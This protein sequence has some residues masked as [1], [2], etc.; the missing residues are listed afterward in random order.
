MKDVWA[1]RAS[2]NVIDAHKDYLNDLTRISSREYKPTT[3]DILLARVRTTQVIMERYRIDGIEF[4]M[5][6]VG[7][8]RSERRK[9]IDCFDQVRRCHLRRRPQ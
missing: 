3:Q 2:I 7:G 5:Y 9:W 4:E 8:Q 6:D 1:K